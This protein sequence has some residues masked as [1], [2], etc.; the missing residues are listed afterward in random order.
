MEAVL[1]WGL[2]L[3]R[4][5]QTIANPALN[6]VMKAVT[7]L[8]SA[9][10]YLIM[11]P[12]VYW[13]IDERK[14]LRLGLTILVSAWA[15]VSLKFLFS[16]P[17]P[18][19]PA[20]DPSVD[21]CMIREP[22]GGFPSGHAQSSLVLW[23]IA[24]SWFKKKYIYFIAALICLV[25]SFSRVYLGMHFPTDIL[26]GWLIGGVVLCGFFLLGPIIEK[27]LIKGGYRAWIIAA[28]AMS[29]IMILYRP[30]KDILLAGGMMLGI[31]AGYTL[32]SKYVG[33][34]GSAI[35]S[36]SKSNGAKFLIL[37]ARFIIGMAI[38]QAVVILG[39]KFGPQEDSSV[40][41]LF[42]FIKYAVAA[43]WVGVGAPW[44]FTKLRLAK[45]GT[46]QA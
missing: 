27:L 12:L 46:V 6:S 44:V 32:N 40:F 45:S 39:S 5:I 20:Y 24:A 33:F 22:Y 4:S 19:F 11:I 18:F 30:A 9:N 1:Q 13:C 10:A 35:F 8:G 34:S 2:D 38:L 17:R 43:L 14:G 28:A 7:Q 41:E 16:Q 31:G 15:N 36:E 37:A 23:T 29:F 25:V 3:I 26:G 42:Y 21:I